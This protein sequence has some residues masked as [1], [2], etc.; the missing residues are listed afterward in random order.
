[1]STRRFL[2]S[3][4]ASSTLFRSKAPRSGRLEAAFETIVAAISTSLFSESSGPRVGEK[5]F[6]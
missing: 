3:A 4:S 1:M 6:A 2:S 5:P